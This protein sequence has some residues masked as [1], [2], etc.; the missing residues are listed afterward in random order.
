MKF[1]LIQFEMELKELGTKVKLEG[2]CE[3][4]GS[5]ILIYLASK[6]PKGTCRRAVLIY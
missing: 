1:G 2:D 4:A 5:K 6:C 3:I